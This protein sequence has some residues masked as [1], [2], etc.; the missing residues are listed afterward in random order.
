ML[1]LG[2]TA[3]C[4]L[5]WLAGASFA[6]DT[7]SVEGQ[8][9]IDGEA[10]E[11]KPLIEQGAAVKD[12]QFCSAQA[13]PNDAMMFDKETKG[14]ANIF[15]YLQK[16]PANMPESVKKSEEKELTFDQKNCRFLPH[17]MVVRTDQTVR[18]KSSDDVPHNVHTNPFANTA[19][20]VIVQ[21]NDQKG[22]VIAM[23]IKEARP[24]KVV[25]DLHNWMVAWWLVVDHPYAAVTGEDG[26]FKIEN[27]PPGTHEFR[28][29]HE[30][31][32]YIDRKLE[33][34]FTVTVKAGETAKLGPVKVPVKAFQ[35]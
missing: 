2:I 33:T 27:L 17:G 13:V 24:V 35:E 28:V 23:P 30:A 12:A 29:W 32:G 6:A 8:F 14:I 10:P 18:C 19:E 5:L 34:K 15:V 25:C 4:G 22:I 9:I 31:A 11:A 3:V 1:R 26:T 7:G 21:A 16:A 20:N